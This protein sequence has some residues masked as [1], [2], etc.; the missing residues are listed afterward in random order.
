MTRALIIV[1]IAIGAVSLYVTT[2]P[3]GQQAVTPKQ[4]AALT[5]R[6]PRR[7]APRRSGSVRPRCGN[8]ARPALA[9]RRHRRRAPPRTPG[10]RSVPDL[11]VAVERV[12]LH[13]CLPEGL[14]QMNELLGRRSMRR[15]G[16][17]DDVLLD[18]HRAHV[19][20][21]EPQRHLTHLH[22]LRDP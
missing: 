14:D 13:G 17:R 5:S 8:A 10:D 15:A 6:G 7:G 4:F 3:A 11:D 12:A 21:T 16:R 20:G 18:H 19:V 22:P 9:R 1:A 2:A